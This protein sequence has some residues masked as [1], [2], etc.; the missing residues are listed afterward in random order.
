MKLGKVLPVVLLAAGA[1]VGYAVYKVA[2][3]KIELEKAHQEDLLDEVI[4][5]KVYR[6]SE[7]TN[8]DNE[9]LEKQLT[10][11]LEGEGSTEE[12]LLNEEENLNQ[13]LSQILDTSNLVEIDAE[14]YPHLS[15]TIIDA[16]ETFSD[17]SIDNLFQEGDIALLE[18]PIQH[19]VTF[20]NEED[21][22]EFKFII[23]NDEF[24]ITNGG[25][26]M[27][28]VVSHITT[29]QKDLLLDKIL[30]IAD[31]ANSVDGVYHGWE[32]KVTK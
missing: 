19:L 20:K 22:N 17:E 29:M 11:F 23:Q 28:I 26:A 27:E 30:Y 9:S 10:P 8:G 32:A 31:I 4:Y 24:V 13:A 2:K 16:I 21:M 7:E 6:K 25:T 1:A 5:Q 14:K 3:E 15:R 12:E 18:R